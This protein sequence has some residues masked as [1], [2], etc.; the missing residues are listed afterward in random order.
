MKTA[1]FHAFSLKKLWF[2]PMKPMLS[3]ARS[4][5]FR[6]KKRRF[7]KLSPVF[8]GINNAY[9]A[10]YQRLACNAKNKRF[11]SSKDNAPANIGSLCGQNSLFVEF[12]HRHSEAHEK[13]T[14]TQH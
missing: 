11:S 6:S 1:S 3:A 13:K 8:A 7:L 10:D 9:Y 2:L 5:G 12:I 14:E 4:G